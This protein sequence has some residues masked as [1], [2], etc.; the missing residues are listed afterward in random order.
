M[1]KMIIGMIAA[2]LAFG[3]MNANAQ[4]KYKGRNHYRD[5]Q[6][7]IEAP[8]PLHGSHAASA[9][10]MHRHVPKH[11]HA[12]AP[13]KHVIHYPAPRPVVVYHP[14]PIPVLPPPA[15]VHHQHHH[16]SD[17][18]TVAAVTTG[19]VVTAALLSILK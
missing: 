19:A 11:H 2:M 10:R 9:Y 17:V 3:S 13:R 1:K 14:T 12:P 15:R 6:Y 7:T 5:V 16:Y 8:A 4:G 18:G